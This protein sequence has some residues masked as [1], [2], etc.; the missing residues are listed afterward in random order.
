MRKKEFL[1]FSAL[2][3]ELSRVESGRVG[4]Y[5]AV[6]LSVKRFKHIVLHRVTGVVVGAIV[7]VENIELLKVVIIGGFL[8]LRDLITSSVHMNVSDAVEGT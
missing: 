6:Y 1:C 3:I 5:I 8:G 2:I 7:R 4:L